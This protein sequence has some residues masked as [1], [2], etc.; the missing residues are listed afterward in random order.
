MGDDDRDG[1]PPIPPPPPLPPPPSPVSPP[2][3]GY[4]AQWA[5]GKGEISECSVSDILGDA[6][7][8]YRDNARPLLR[9]AAIIVVPLT[10]L[11]GLIGRVILGPAT[12]SSIIVVV[13]L[14]SFVITIMTNAILQAVLMRAAAQ[15]VLQDPVDIK[16][17]Y[18]WGLRRFASVLWVSF[19]ATIASGLATLLFVIPGIIV[20]IRL[21]VSVPAL[22]VEDVRGKQALGR[23]WDLVRGHFWHVF[24]A[25]LLAGL[26]AGIVT[27]VITAFGGHN[28]VLRLIFD[29]IA[30]IIV[31]P[32][33][34]LITVMVYLDL[35]ARA[36]TEG[37]PVSTL[38]TELRRGT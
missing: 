29:T 30:R 13:V 35:R 4:P 34:A 23:S 14:L 26:L 27:S 6:F 37:L 36:R 22:V 12:S 25:L 32:Y 10:I 9:V 7:R 19:L 3:S 28:T 33:S 2:S 24:G 11:P 38:R 17:S 16:A 15:A 21:A 31:A 1:P 20:G 18:R 8:F 5:Q